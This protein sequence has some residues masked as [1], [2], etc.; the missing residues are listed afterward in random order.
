M[1]VSAS[2]KTSYTINVSALLYDSKLAEGNTKPAF[3]LAQKNIEEFTITSNPKKINITLYKLK[4]KGLEPF[5]RGLAVY[6]QANL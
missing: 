2:K 4:L 5:H 3:T 6:D 1:A